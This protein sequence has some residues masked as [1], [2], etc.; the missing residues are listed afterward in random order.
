MISGRTRDES[1]IL[2]VLTYFLL[3]TTYVRTYVRTDYS[4]YQAS[5]I[6]FRTPFPSPPLPP[7]LTSLSLAGSSAGKG[8][9]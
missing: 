3:S 7:H 1:F 9:L 4:Q 6:S 5:I 2:V 8:V